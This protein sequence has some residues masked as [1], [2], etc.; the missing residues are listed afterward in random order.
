M[1]TPSDTGWDLWKRTQR[2]LLPVSRLV[3]SLGQGLSLGSPSIRRKPKVGVRWWRRLVYGLLS[4]GYRGSGFGNSLHWHSNSN[5][6]PWFSPGQIQISSFSPGLLLLWKHICFKI[7]PRNTLDYRKP[8]PPDIWDWGRKRKEEGLETWFFVPLW[9]GS[10]TS[11]DQGTL[12]CLVSPKL[13][14]GRTKS[15]A[16]R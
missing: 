16:Y 5:N 12:G 11:K 9:S 7:G 14:T 1:Q 2:Y 15:T 10:I 13:T 3:C 6:N 4:K 8:S